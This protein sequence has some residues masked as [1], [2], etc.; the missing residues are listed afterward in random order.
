MFCGCCLSA[1]L[2]D[3]LTPQP[4]GLVRVSTQGHL[5]ELFAYGW[6]AA[7]AQILDFVAPTVSC[8]G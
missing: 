6:R 4:T 7:A 3:V 1:T 2:A 5:F 8:Y